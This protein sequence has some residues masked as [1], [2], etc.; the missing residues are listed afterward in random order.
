MLLD[1]L[2]LHTRFRRLRRCGALWFGA[3]AAASMV[4]AASPTS[5]FEIVTESHREAAHGVNSGP[6]ATR[7]VFTYKLKYKGKALS[8]SAAASTD[9]SKVEPPETMLDKAYFLD[10]RGESIALVA[11]NGSTFLVTETQGQP[12]IERLVPT[13]FQGYQWLDGANGQPA[14]VSL[15][16]PGSGNEPRSLIEGKLLVL[17]DNS[18]IKIGVLDIGRRAFHLL[19][20]PDPAQR[21]SQ[22]SYDDGYRANGA[23]PGRARALSPGRGQ[24]VMVG[25]KYVNDKPAV[26]LLVVDFVRR[27]HVIVSLDIDATRL[28]ALQKATPQWLDR[29]YAWTTTADGI[30]RL[31]PRRP[32]PMTLW[33]GFAT[34]RAAESA[35]Y[36]LQPVAASAPAAFVEYLERTHGAVRLP[37]KP[38]ETDQ[39]VRIQADTFVVR[40]YATSQML[41]FEPAL[42]LYTESAIAACQTI[43]AAYDKQLASGAFQSQ[44]TH[45]DVSNLW[46]EH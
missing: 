2:R 18:G 14:P 27:T 8:F 7:K 1:H 34:D 38:G 16:A 35:A 15:A 22:E 25:T 20:H 12:V 42:G 10:E 39:T 31:A 11:A 33:T 21:L 6:F 19:M 32:V 5:S 40:L 44:F 23:V 28:N 45:L 43:A 46:A 4:H 3:L 24:F 17:L 13:A 30:E 41:V 36:R 37:A 26:S 9:G 29:F